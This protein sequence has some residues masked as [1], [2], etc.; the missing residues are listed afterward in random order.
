MTIQEM[1]RRCGMER[2]NIRFYEREGL[3]TPKRLD[4]GYRD[5]SEEDVQTLLR[6]RLLRSLQ[7][8]LEDIRALQSGQL[9]LSDSLAR[10]LEALARQQQQTAQAAQVCRSI[11]EANVSYGTLNAE[12]YLAQLAQSPAF[13]VPAKAPAVPKEDREPPLGRPIRRYFA[14]MLDLSL[15]TLLI[16]GLLAL[17]GVKLG[18]VAAAARTLLSYLAIGLMLFVE[19]LLLHLLGTTPGKALLGLHIE[20]PEGQKPSYGE[21]RQRTWEVLWRGYGLGIPFYSLWRLWQSYCS[22]EEGKEL[23][24]EF[25]FVQTLRDEKIW[26]VPAYVLARLLPVFLTVVIGLSQFLAPNR[27]P[28]TPAEFVEN[29][30]YYADLYEVDFGYDVLQPNGTWKDETPPNVGV[31]RLDGPPTPYEIETDGEGYVTAVSFTREPEE[32]NAIF[33]LPEGQMRLIALALAGAQEEATLFSNFTTKVEALFPEQV[34][35]TETADGLTTG[36]TGSEAG[37][38]LHCAVDQKGYGAAS[39]WNSFV[40]AADEDAPGTDRYFQMTYRVEI[41]D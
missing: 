32:D 22:C 38:T 19:P 37:V 6:I 30:Y 2:A 16:Y 14:R 8:S 3:L 12:P 35:W 28:L 27:G 26:R 34:Q 24:W 1:E 13:S 4:N 10:Q 11:R 17:C 18:N 5:Y 20:L 7:V 40:A 29:F 23:D 41:D 31:I 21:A 33:F 15:Y 9:A 36:F 39:T 25:G